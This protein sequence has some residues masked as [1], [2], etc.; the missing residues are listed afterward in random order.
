MRISIVFLALFVFFG[1][2]NEEKDSKF[3][4]EI[5]YPEKKSI[6]EFSERD[7]TSKYFE[8]SDCDSVFTSPIKFHITHEFNKPL[9]DLYFNIYIC[10]K[11]IYSGFYKET[12]VSNAIELC[13][14]KKS[15]TYI[16]FNCLD[17][18]NKISYGWA[19]KNSLPLKVEYKIKL[20]YKKN[21]DENSY[22]FE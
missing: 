8:A 1:C 21:S 18:V 22:E 12:I 5:Y 11:I 20:L 6:T 17:S 19:Q 7:T 14:N 2:N 10:D 13:A 4:K 16:R 15:G 3:L 9:N